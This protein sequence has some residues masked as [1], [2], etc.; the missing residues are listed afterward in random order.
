MGIVGVVG[1]VFLQKAVGCCWG[2]FG[3]LCIFLVA[4]ALGLSLFAFDCWTLS[5]L[6]E[7]STELIGSVEKTWET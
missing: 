3:S 7:L 2:T 1:S 5:E 4:S 6:A